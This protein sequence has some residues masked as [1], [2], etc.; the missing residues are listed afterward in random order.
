MKAPNPK[1]QAPEKLQTPSSD[2][3][4]Q[5][6]MFDVSSTPGPRS[7]SRRFLKA[8]AMITCAVALLL[9]TAT[10]ELIVGISFPSEEGFTPLF[11]GKDL[12]G[13]DGN[14]ALWSVKDGAIVGQTSEQ[15][16]LKNNTFLIWT[17]GTVGDF[18]LRCS[19]KIE[20]LNTNGFANSG[21][22]YRSKVLDP[23]GW[24]VG[25]YQADMEAGKTYTGILYEE[26]MTRG[27]MAARGEKVLWD[28][29][30]EKKVTG[31]L[32]SSDELQAAIKQG[33]WND[34]VIIAQG[35]HLQH[36]I[37]SKQTVDVTDDC[38]SKRAM[39]GVLAL[40][41][42]AGP[43]MKVQFRELRLRTSSAG[44]E[45]AADPL[46]PFQGTWEI[47]SIEKDGS[48]VPQDDIAG[49][50]VMISGSAYKLINKDNVSKG[51][52]SLD[53]SKE[54]KQMDVQHQGE[55]GDSHSMPAIYDVTA[56]TLRVCYN[57]EGGTRPTSFSTKPDSGFLS[58]VYKRKAE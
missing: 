19:F 48:P 24:V 44:K 42:H 51:T 16:P 31:S 32:G 33:D 43:P 1:N 28:K 14:P 36:F 54:P 20:P 23:K 35:N 7:L 11:N 15:N 45:A 27:I 40:Q 5:S 26:R 29:N 22:Q 2:T 47:V 56:D 52:F 9:Q 41:L 37:N 25:G 38:E 10:A 4:I 55:N 53:A 21:I 58:V 12:T 30:C 49:M 34:Y 46:A 39:N 3:G 13:W 18:E 6:W 57:P 17:N 50:T 8:A